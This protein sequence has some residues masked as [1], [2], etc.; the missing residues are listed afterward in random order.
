MNCRQ[1][2]LALVTSSYQRF[3]LSGLDNARHAGNAGAQGD[4]G[5]QQ[6]TCKDAE[7][8]AWGKIIRW[9]SIARTRPCGHERGRRQRRSGACRYGLMMKPER[10]IDASRT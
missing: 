10:I 9:H 8:R 6:M 7:R 1:W 2:L 5:D 4:M 3:Q